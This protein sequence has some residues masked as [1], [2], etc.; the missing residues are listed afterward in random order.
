MTRIAQTNTA[1]A[2]NPK[3]VFFF[4]L[5]LIGSCGVSAF[6]T[7]VGGSDFIISPILVAVFF[8]TAFATILAS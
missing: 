5:G 6:S 1:P 7:V 3:M 8:A 4:K 2:K